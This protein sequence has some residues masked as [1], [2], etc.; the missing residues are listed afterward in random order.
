MKKIITW[1]NILDTKKKK[2]LLKILKFIKLERCRKIIYP[3]NKNMFSAFKYTSFKK[4]K[5]VILGQDPYHNK[6]QANGLAFSVNYG[7]KIPPS[8]KNIFKELKRSIKFFNFPKHG[9]LLKWANQGILLLNTIL[10]VEKN[11]PNSHKNIGWSY[12][13]DT[14][15]KKISFYKKNVIFLLLG[16]N[17]QKKVDLINFN[18]H[19]ILISSHPSPY[20]AKNGFLGCNH[21]L[22]INSILTYL[23]KDNID[24]NL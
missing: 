2:Y 18:K 20:S 4:I 6:C 16:K 8:L 7:V 15:I 9:N 12:F 14:I 21:F 22:K 5:V 19:F 24:W 10:T 1:K 3:S 13:T 11:K 23:K 17:A